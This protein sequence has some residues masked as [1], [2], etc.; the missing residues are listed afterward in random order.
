MPVIRPAT[1]PTDLAA[2]RSLFRNYA[3]SLN[4]D[5][6][7]Q[8]FEDELNSLPGAYA[9]PDGTVILAT[10]AAIAVGVVALRALQPGVAEM[11]RLFV[12]DDFRGQGLGRRLAMASIDAARARNFK[13]IRLDT[14]AEM[15]PAIGLYTSLGFG[16]I[17]PYCHNPLPTAR[18]FEL[19]LI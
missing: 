14:V 12:S 1:F 3:A 13:T 18:F 8:D 10:D 16:S 17:A 2:V 4:F 7:F 5:L 9:E 15:T 11:K 19:K 6:K